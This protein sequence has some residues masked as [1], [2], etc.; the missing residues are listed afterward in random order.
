MNRFFVTGPQRSGTTFVANCLAKS[1]QIP[2]ID[3]MEFD[4][5]FYGMFK[6][7]ASQHESWVAHAPGLFHKVF[8]VINDFENTTIVVVRRDVEKIIKSQE[9]INWDSKQEKISMRIDENDQRP[10]AEIKYNYW[11]KWKNHIPR[12]VEYSYDDF[13]VHPLWVPDEMRQNF[14]PKQWQIN[15]DCQNQMP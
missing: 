7:I 15:E 1:F 13:E 4:V 2:Y 10:I 11:D 3:E 9:R 8:D 12:Y 14:A 6:K 5:Y